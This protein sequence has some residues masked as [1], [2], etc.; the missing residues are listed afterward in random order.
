MRRILVIGSPGAG[1][2]T[3]ARRLAQHLGLP[4]VHLDREFFGPGWVEPPRAEWRKRVSALV[5]KPEWVMDGNYGSTFDL[6]IPRATDIVWLDLPRWRC[7]LNVLWRV[8]RHYGRVRP[9]LGPGCAER[10]DWS[11][12]RWIWTYPKKVRP[13]TARLLQSLGPDKRVFVLRSWAELPELERHLVLGR[14]AA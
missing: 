10:F 5:A 7:L 2:S 9:D 8:L 12:M 13:G 14:E 3:A 4:L 1:K 11:F 6:R